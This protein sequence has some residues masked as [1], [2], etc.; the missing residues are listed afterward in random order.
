MKPPAFDYL[1]AESISDVLDGLA[2]QGGDARVLAGG[3]SLMAMPNMRLAKPKLLIDIMRLRELRQIERK[4][5]AV[6][7]GAGV[8]QADLLA[9]PDL[10]ETLPLVALALPWV[11]H[12][13]TRSR[14]T[15][16]GS[17]AHADPS[18]EMPLTLVALGGEVFLR[19]AKR[20]RRVA[21]KDFFSGMMLTARADDELIESISLPV[22]KGSRVA[23]REVARRHGDFAIVACAAMKTPTGVRLAVGGV[24][25]VPTARDWPRLDGTALD[26]ALNAFAYELG[27]HDDVHATARYRRDLVRM[28]GRD[29]IGE[30]L[31]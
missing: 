24:A 6:V 22:I 4:G 13:Q 12:M 26:D 3:Q 5:D 15:I 16:C 14:G 21:A 8:R 25:D 31:Q 9:W 1:R 7:I 23:F 28:I 10:A 20:R 2:Q 18:A 30:V 19:N 27:A 17:L 11:G 29:L